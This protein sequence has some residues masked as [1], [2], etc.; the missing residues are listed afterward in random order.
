VTVITQGR[1]TKN[2]AIFSD[3]IFNSKTGY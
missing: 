1:L 2:V 3:W